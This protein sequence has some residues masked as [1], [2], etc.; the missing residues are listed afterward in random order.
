MDKI[1]TMLVT[2]TIIFEVHKVAFKHQHQH[3]A[4]VEGQSLNSLGA[5]LSAELISP[6]RSVHEKRTLRDLNQSSPSSWENWRHTCTTCAIHSTS[7][8]FPVKFILYHVFIECEKKYTVLR[9]YLLYQSTFFSFLAGM[10]CFKK[11]SFFQMTHITVKKIIPPN[12]TCLTMPSIEE[13]SK[14]IS[15][16]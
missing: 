9:L 3:Q 1:I 4:D 10:K 14:A 12:A 8:R 2:L 11:V 5:N 13:S 15:D 6:L 7:L 16:A